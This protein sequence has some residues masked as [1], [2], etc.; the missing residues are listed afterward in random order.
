MM[1]L[2]LYAILQREAICQRILAWGL[3]D[4]RRET[5]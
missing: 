3:M 1:M 4:P 2:K 5:S